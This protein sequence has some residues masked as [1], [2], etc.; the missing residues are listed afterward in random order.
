LHGCLNGRVVTRIPLACLLLAFALVPVFGAIRIAHRRLFGNYASLVHY[1]GGI[2]F[3][4]TFIAFV[5]T[6][7]A[8]VG[9]SASFG[10]Y[11]TGLIPE[12]FLYLLPQKP[13]HAVLVEK[14]S[15]RAYLYRSEDLTRPYRI[16]P[17]STGEKS[18]P[19][20]ARNDKRTPE[21]IYYL[22]DS[23]Q[24][25][26]LAPIY[27]VRAFPIDYPNPLDRVL[28]RMGYGIWIHGTNDS[29]K[30]KDTKG[31]IVFRNEDILDLSQYLIEG[32]TPIIITQKINLIEEEMLQ[33][34][35]D[36]L[37]KLVIE[38]LTSWSE[39]RVEQYMSFYGK[40]FVSQGKD[41]NQWRAHKKRLSEQYGVMDI[42]IDGLQILREN[43]VV[44]AR[45]EQTYRADGFFSNGV[46]RLYLMK[47]S[48]EWKI[49]YEFFRKKKEIAT[50][51]SADVVT[52]RELSSIKRFINV[53]Q[54][55]WQE[56]DIERYMDAYAEDFH[57][58]GLDREGWRRHKAEL[59]RTYQ[60]IYVEVRDL[61]VQILSPVKAIVRFNQEYSSDRHSDYGRKT[62]RLVKRDGGW[63]IKG[64]T[65]IPLK[66]GKA[67]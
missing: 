33:K 23:L 40:D 11:A 42:R 10:N 32:Q 22:T 43:G 55:A 58:G 25:E 64:E 46:K 2:L 29:L 31:C 59:N 20:S 51:V 60:R 27:G 13:G 50:S 63:R 41:W 45:F 47:K 19:K 52:K 16:Y 56:K 62:L 18:G 54:Q 7:G 49:T 3:L 30:P 26:E 48:P 8:S 28:G 66:S 65:W 57:S 37:R 34:E 9:G 24:E 38:W 17:C 12:S 67:R 14:S 15:Q 6:A 35:G 44:L 39:S 4:V 36:E 53:W 5:H 61:R 1:Q 21:G